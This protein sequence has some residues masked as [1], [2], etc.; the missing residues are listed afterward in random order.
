MR[1]V[2]FERCGGVVSGLGLEVK[3]GFKEDEKNK[4]RRDIMRRNRNERVVKMPGIRDWLLKPYSGCMRKD[5]YRLPNAGCGF[6]LVEVLIVAVILC[7]AAAMIIPMMSSAASMQI[8]SAANMIAADLEYAKSMAISRGQ[9]FSVVFDKTAESYRIENQDGDIIPHPVKKGFDYE[10]S[11]SSDSRLN[12]V[13]IADVD[14]N[15]TSEVKFDYLGTPDNGGDITLQ[16]EGVIVTITVE[17]VTG[18]IT[19]SQ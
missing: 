1:F 11:F 6:T 15:S 2:A 8:S 14:F 19:I 3:M 7:V 16:A 10:V 5:R 18:F 9:N 12:K 13:D 17:S 4:V